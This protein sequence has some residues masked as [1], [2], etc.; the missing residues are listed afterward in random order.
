LIVSPKVIAAHREQATK[1]YSRPDL[2]S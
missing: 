1:I 2:T